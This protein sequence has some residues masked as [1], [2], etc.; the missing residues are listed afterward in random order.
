MHLTAARAR[1]VRAC[2]LEQDLVTARAPGGRRSGP[3]TADS[4]S[5]G[6]GGTTNDLLACVEEVCAHE[7]LVGEAPVHA[8]ARARSTWRPFARRQPAPPHRRQH[9][10][11]R[12]RRWLTKH[13]NW[14]GELWWGVQ[15]SVLLTSCW[16]QRSHSVL[17]AAVGASHPTADP[18]GSARS[19]QSVHTARGAQPG[20]LL[21]SCVQQSRSGTNSISQSAEGAASEATGAIQEYA[22]KH[23]TP[24][25]SASLDAVPVHP[26]SM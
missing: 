25:P 22:K 21:P 3:S 5:P 10:A 16:P 14:T 8:L 7:P 4:C 26:P 20:E 17:R 23:S 24:P 6:D 2:R 1:A 18:R 15:S 9:Y 12:L 13:P 19:R 11:G